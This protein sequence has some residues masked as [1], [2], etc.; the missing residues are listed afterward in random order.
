MRQRR[1]RKGRQ[2]LYTD[3]STATKSSAVNTVKMVNA[4]I[5]M[6]AAST[7]VAALVAAN[8]FGISWKLGNSVNGEYLG[9]IRLKL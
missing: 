7:V 3:I 6:A 4:V 9:P 5:D 2:G 8:L 1:T